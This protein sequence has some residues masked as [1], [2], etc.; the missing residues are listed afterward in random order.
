MAQII[1]ENQIYSNLLLKQKELIHF[2]GTKHTNVDEFVKNSFA[3]TRGNTPVIMPVQ[4]HG[5]TIGKVTAQN[6]Q[7]IFAS[8][9]ALISN[10]PGMCIAVKTAD[11]VPVF[12]F[13]PV[14]KAVAAIHSGWRSTVQNIVAKT[15][16]QLI[17]QYQSRPENLL[18]AIG[19]CIGQKHYEVGGEV[20]DYFEKEPFCSYNAISYTSCKSGKGRLDLNKTIVRQLLEVGL[21]NKNI[22]MLNVCTYD[23]ESEFYSA[24]RDG[25]TTGR[26]INGILLK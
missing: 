6:T 3:E 19:P 17:A 26:M 2:F 11:C 12:L 14:K 15:V 20:L 24:R 5:C 23:N 10:E 18:A 9:D 22:E 25:A 13:D 16:K 1:S 21:K 4:T 7:H 8:T